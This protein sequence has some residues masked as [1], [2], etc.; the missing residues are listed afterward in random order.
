MWITSKPVT[1]EPPTTWILL[2]S[3]IVIACLPLENM[4][5]NLTQQLLQPAEYNYMNR[6]CIL[7][8]IKYGYNPCRANHHHCSLRKHPVHSV[9][10]DLE[11][12]TGL[13]LTQYIAQPG[14]ISNQ[15]PPPLKSRQVT[16]STG[17][18]SRKF[19][20]RNAFCESRARGEVKC[21]KKFWE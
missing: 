16:D 12:D 15:A 9:S 5:L 14:K 3:M 20:R 1:R 18:P 19:S 17:N 4:Y 8:K 2:S 11:T 21:T 7:E 10:D 13:A 6:I